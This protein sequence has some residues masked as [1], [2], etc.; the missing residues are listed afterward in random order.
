MSAS[1]QLWGQVHNNLEQYILRQVKDPVAAQDL[2]QDV[3]LK[4][5]AKL[6]QL[7]E[8]E[9]AAPWLFRIAKNTIIDHYRQAAN[10]PVAGLVT[11]PAGTEQED[12]TQEFAYCI[13]PFIDSLPE[14]Y[15]EAL[16]LVEIQGL[17]QKELAERLGISYSGAKSRVQRG[18]EMLKEALLECCHIQADRYGNILGYEKRE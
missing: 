10:Q 5:Q 17:S 16:L 8:P 11:E 14:K 15:R 9:K 4:M 2:L 7:R 6:P 1:E 3:F 13:R 18:R 12:I